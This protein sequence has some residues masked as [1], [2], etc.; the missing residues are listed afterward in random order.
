MAPDIYVAERAS[1]DE[2]VAAVVRLADAIL[3]DKPDLELASLTAEI[4]WNEYFPAA[5]KIVMKNRQEYVVQGALP[6]VVAM[7]NEAE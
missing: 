3:T 1:H 5:T 7:L 6:E 4:P 2:R